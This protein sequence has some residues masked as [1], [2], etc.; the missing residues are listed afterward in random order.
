M[1][2][3]KFPEHL[4]VCPK[5]RKQVFTPRWPEQDKLWPKV[6]KEGWLEART[7]MKKEA[8]DQKPRDDSALHP[9]L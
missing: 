9:Q 7:W 3:F 5:F 8:S 6:V 1:V 4:L 2:S